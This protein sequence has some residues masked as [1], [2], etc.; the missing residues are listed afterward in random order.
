MAF[1]IIT[2]PAISRCWLTIC[3]SWIMDWQWLYTHVHTDILNI[4]EHLVAGLHSYSQTHRQWT[5]VII[6]KRHSLSLHLF[7]W[8][9][10]HLQ[11]YVGV[12]ESVWV[13]ILVHTSKHSPHSARGLRCPDPN[14]ITTMST[15]CFIITLLN[16][17]ALGQ[18]KVNTHICV[19]IC[20]CAVLFL[21]L[22]TSL[23]SVLL[24][25]PVS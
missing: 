6:Y 14:V 17:T 21:G 8:L 22:L 7:V 9:H 13:C 1:L 20:V 19:Y 4:Q 12:C 11:V 25:S 16:Q 18:A 3:H 23:L 24:F 2:R 10:A 5:G 15:W